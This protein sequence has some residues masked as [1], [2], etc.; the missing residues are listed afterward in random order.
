[1]AG[2][3]G[4]FGEVCGWDRNL[5]QQPQ[6][7]AGGYIQDTDGEEYQYPLYE[8]QNQ[9]AGCG[10]AADSFRGGEPGGAE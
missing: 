6:R 7:P 5:R 3:G 2:A 10:Y 8:H 4:R 9:Q 1:M